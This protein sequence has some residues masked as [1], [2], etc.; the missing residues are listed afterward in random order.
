MVQPRAES[1]TRRRVELDRLVS[2]DFK[3]GNTAS[4]V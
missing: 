2:V 1:G 3:S 4:S